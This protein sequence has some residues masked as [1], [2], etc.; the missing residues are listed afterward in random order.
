MPAHRS[1]ARKFSQADMRRKTRFCRFFQTEEGCANGASCAFAHGATEL[2]CFASATGS[3]SNG[4]DSTAKV[5]AAETLGRASAAPAASSSP[6]SSRECWADADG[7][8]DDEW[9]S[10]WAPPSQPEMRHFQMA[11]HSLSSSSPAVAK[12]ASKKER[13]ELEA[14]AI[15][16]KRAALTNSVLEG[17]LRQAQ[18]PYVYKE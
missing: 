12:T 3:G 13:R 7:D 15:Q 6:P 11:A 2:Q 9:K 18:A 14:K 1:Q 17:L 10:M 4:D 8:E 5:C 16:A